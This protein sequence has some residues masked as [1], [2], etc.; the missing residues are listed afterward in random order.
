MDISLYDGIRQQVADTM[1]R[2]YRT[3]LTTTS[4][5][6]I[7]FRLSDELFCITP[8][9]LDKAGLTGEVIAV[10]GFDGTNHTPHLKLSIESEMHRRVLMARRDINAV[11]HAHPVYAS[12]FTAM[13]KPINTHLLAES[14]FLIGEPYLAPYRRMGTSELADSVVEGIQTTQV[15]LLENHGVL[16]VGTSLIEAFDLIEVLENSARMTFITEMMKLTGTAISPLDDQRC[17]E[18]NEMKK[19]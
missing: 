17:D 14:Y 3:R 4:G 18:L 7:S 15:V 5:G 12:S 11:V 16:T 9:Q 2:L 8:S 10:V 13:N 19:G 6:N 1:S